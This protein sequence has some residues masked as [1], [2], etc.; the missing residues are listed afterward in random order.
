MM[1]G[2]IVVDPSTGSRRWRQARPSRPPSRPQGR[3]GARPSDGSLA[4]CLA[5]CRQRRAPL[6]GGNRGCDAQH[7]RALGSG[8]AWWSSGCAI[9]RAHACF[10]RT[11]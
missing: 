3:D 10:R 6:V 1:A 9:P 11:V 8:V 2:M 7:F 5:R 4:E